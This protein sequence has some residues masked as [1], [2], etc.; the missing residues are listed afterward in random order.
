[1]AE[2]ISE[3][4]IGEFF[5]LTPDETGKQELAEIKG[6]LKKMVF[7]HGHD[8]VTIDEEPDGMYFIESGTAVVLGREGEQLNILHIGQ[9]FGEYGVLSGQKRLSTVRALGRTVVFKMESEDLLSFLQKHP[10]IYGEFM[11]RVYGQLSN[12]HSQILALSGMR[13]GVLTH[14]SN[15]VPLSHKQLLINY[16]GLLLIYILASL[17]IPAD[18]SFPVFVIPIAFM[19]LYVF[20]TKRTVESLITSC[21]LA[22]ILVYRAGLFPGFTDALMDTMGAADNVFTVLVMALMGAMINLIVY[23]GGV[24]AFEKSAAKT[25]KTPRGIFLSSL[26]IMT[27][28]S[29]DDGL[30]MLCASY[31]A[32]TPAKEKGVVREKL[33]LFYSLLPTVLSSFFPLSLWAIFVIGTLSATVKSDALAIFCRSI[34]FNFFSI[35]TVIAMVLFA[36]GK[37][38]RTRQI[39]TAEARYK[40]TGAL[41]PAGSEK[42]L[43]IHETEVW[44]KITNVMLPIAVLAVS[45]LAVRSFVTKSFVVDSAVGLM[46][47]LAFMFLMYCFREIMSPEQF[48]EH[49]VDGISG[50]TLPIIM[51]LLTM[52]FSSMLDTLGL[53]VYLAEAI[54]IVDEYMFLLPA[55]TF[56]LA[57]LLTMLLGSSW[58]MYAIT[59]PVVLGLT[60]TLG[61]N[62]LLFVGAIA[63]AG[64]AGEK[65]CA[66]TA[67]ALNV[68]TAVGINPLAARRVRISY[69]A[70]ITVV[71][72]LCYVGAGL[73]M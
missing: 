62:P 61:L 64:I 49:L 52:C 56:V 25:G 24:T 63:G 50:V 65:N 27:A 54:E 60:K 10:D 18:T 48:M 36:F 72:A 73:L 7:E 31:A 23:S 39:K 22:A 68:G 43:S 2:R 26:G 6:K 41:W 47:T 4:Y 44:G 71:T 45:S 53:H 57:M 20:V 66:F 1:M 46:V 5:G 38:P 15:T 9:Y 17:F 67:E 37:L 58:A 3:K 19:L 33:A 42:Y 16:G 35:L 14:P 11:K 13:K 12:K 30:N 34:P 32:Y 29:I 40:E 69:S 21:I 55:A 70:A 51:Y 59:F 28:T 8:I